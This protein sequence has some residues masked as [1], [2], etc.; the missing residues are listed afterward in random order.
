MNSFYKTAIVLLFPFFINAQNENGL[1][2]HEEYFNN[3][4]LKAEGW[5]LNGKKVQYWK[6]YN[7]Y[8]VLKSEGHFENDVRTKYWFFYRANGSLWKEGTFTNGIIDDWWD[9]YDTKEQIIERC[10]YKSGLKNGYR[11]VFVNAKPKRVEKFELDT[12]TDQWTSYA[13]FVLDN[14]PLLSTDE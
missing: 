2:Y 5:M 8:G 1:V 7:T 12:K 10:Q 11:V 4:V 9:F 14:G 13:S 6:F 3:K